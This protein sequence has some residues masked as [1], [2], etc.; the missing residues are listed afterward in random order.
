MGDTGG[1]DWRVTRVGRGGHGWV[2]RKGQT[3][4]SRRSRVANGR[5]PNVIRQ[6]A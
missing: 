2:T 3:G 1:S 4:G 6:A 5:Y